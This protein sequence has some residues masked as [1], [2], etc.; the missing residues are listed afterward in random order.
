MKE[1]KLFFSW[2]SDDNK[3]KKLLSDAIKKAVKDI[4]VYHNYNITIE[5]STSN[6]PGSPQIVQ[7]ILDKIDSCDIF[8]ADITPVCK[9]SKQLG[10]NQSI[11][12]QVPNPNV[13]MELGYA[14]SA[15]GMHYTICAAHQGEWNS[16]DLPFD[17]NHNRIYP[18]TSSN[19]DLSGSILQVIDYIKKHGRHRHKATPYLIHRF[20]LQW[21]KI[22][23]KLAKKDKRPN[24][25]AFAEPIIY[26]NDRMSKAFHG[27]RGL[28][29]YT[30][31][32]DIR[33]CLDELFATP[34]K[35][36]S[37][38]DNGGSYPIFWWFRG[39]AAMYV[40]KYRRLG[41][42]HFLINEME[43]NVKRI[44]AYVDPSG[45]Y[46]GQYVYVETNPDKPTGL[47][48]TRTKE[49]IKNSQKEYGYCW[50]EYGVFRLF[51]LFNK[52]VTLD[53]FDDGHTNFLGKTISPSRKNQ[54]HRSRFLTP[55]NLIISSQESSFNCDQFYDSNH[56]FNRLLN[57]EMTIEEF[58][59]YMKRFPKPRDDWYYR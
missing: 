29:T 43:L 40:E 50:E 36:K 59:D 26:F 9:Y 34:L 39:S 46:Y 54:E 1:F 25:Y 44:V 13:L 4:R 38:H 31:V 6:T 10:N 52:R 47:Y 57:G 41:K 28:V 23:D 55:Y 32:K 22:K 48:A 37:L 2:Q 33:R 35:L 42:R 19:C 56:Y 20:N 58:N 45:R 16:N 14:L 3:T 15:V 49:E 5:E 17:I 27:K 51:R 24:E 18:F 8:L 7:T 30:R 11:T 21:E 12:K 53:E